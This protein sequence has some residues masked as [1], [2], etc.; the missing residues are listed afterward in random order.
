MIEATQKTALESSGFRDMVAFYL[1][2]NQYA[3]DIARV[4]GINKLLPITEVE[5]A[6]D[7]VKGL[8]NLRG[9]VVT[10]LDLNLRLGQA[11]TSVTRDSRI[12]IVSSEEEGVGLLVDRLND[13]VHAASDLIE[14]PP[15]NLDGIQGDFFVGV[16]KAAESLIG[17]LD[18]DELL[19][20]SE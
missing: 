16:Y 13:V 11:S 2:T 7:Y 4:R 12:I 10:V 5:R 9:Q 17:I 20:T 8:V 18:V 3:L 6:P 1:G 19:K 14:A 15:A